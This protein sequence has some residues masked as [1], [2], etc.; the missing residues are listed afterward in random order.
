MIFP[1]LWLKKQGKVRIDRSGKLT[2]LT[3]R[4]EKRFPNWKIAPLYYVIA[5][6]CTEKKVTW[7]TMSP[8]LYCTSV[9]SLTL[10][11]WKENNRHGCVQDAQ[12]FEESIKNWLMLL[13]HQQS[14][15]RYL[16]SLYICRVDNLNLNFLFNTNHTYIL[17]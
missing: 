6:F 16:N 2:V 4:K 12:V 17:N 5:K 14:V 15:W 8:H 7:I 11:S 10:F 1:F 13:W 9:F 3:L